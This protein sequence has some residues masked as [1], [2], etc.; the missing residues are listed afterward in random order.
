VDGKLGSRAGVAAALLATGLA[1]A[2]CTDDA[3]DVEGPRSCEVRDQNAWLHWL[4][5]G[6]YLWNDEMPEVD[7]RDYESADDLV[8]A[9]R[10]PQDRWTRVDVKA[11]SDAFFEEGRFLGLGY[12]T[13]RDEDDALVVSFVYGGSPAAEVG[14][15]RGDR[16]ERVNGFSVDELDDLSAWADV[17]GAN[18]PGVPVKIGFSTP[19]GDDRE[20][21][22]LKSWIDIVTVPTVRIFDTEAGP[23]GYLLFLTFVEPS[24]DELDAAFAQ[25]QAA[26][27]K[28]VVMDLRY[29][30]GGLLAVARH[31][32][33]LVAGEYHAGDVAYRV[34]YNDDLADQNRVLELEELEHSLPLDRVVFL[35]THRTLSASELVINLLSPYLQVTIVGATTG[36]KPFGSHSYD[37]CDQIVFPISFRLSNA[38]GDTDYFDG[39][40]PHCWAE[41]ELGRA[42][43]DPA[44]DSLATALY[45]LAH[46][47]CPVDRADGTR[48]R[49]SDPPRGE[50]LRAVIDSW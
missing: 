43:G 50:G 35:T 44:E 29:N 15:Q 6:Y 25:F 45:T 10:V 23:V 41:D 2:G 32:G 14:M 7:P 39:L 36:G 18:E 46:D 48:A 40:V 16:V 20:E 24:H 19:E 28:S 9:L 42:L 11:E 1:A 31:I 13:V 5:Q 26:G 47:T 4:M 3:F 27:V 17:T 30:G 38:E 8:A 34:E 22:L 37:F 33:S 21:I 12:K 49:P